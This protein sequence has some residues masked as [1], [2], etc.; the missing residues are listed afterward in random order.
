MAVVRANVLALAVAT[1]AYGATASATASI[2][3]FGLCSLLIV[4]AVAVVLGRAAPD[5]EGLGVGP[6]RSRSAPTS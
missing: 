1:T 4:A 3:V 5:Y 6:S 2:V